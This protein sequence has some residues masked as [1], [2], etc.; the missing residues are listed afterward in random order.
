MSRDRFKEWIEA[1]IAPAPY[2]CEPVSDDMLSRSYNNIFAIPTDTHM[3]HI[4]GKDEWII[5]GHMISTPQ[6]VRFYYSPNWGAVQFET[7][8]FW[9]LADFL[10]KHN[11]CAKFEVRNGEKIVK[12]TPCEHYPANEPCPKS[13]TTLTS[14]IPQPIAIIT[15]DHNPIRVKECFESADIVEALNNSNWIK[16]NN[17][18]YDGNMIVGLVDNVVYKI[19]I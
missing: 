3:T 1:G 11:L 10:A 19:N 4:E 17:W 15:K 5:S 2:V 6:W 7:T 16:G 14:N 8:G 12:V 18:L 9:S 13:C